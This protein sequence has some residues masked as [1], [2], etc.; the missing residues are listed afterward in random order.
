MLFSLFKERNCLFHFT[1]DIFTFEIKRECRPLFL[2]I[3]RKFPNRDPRHE[4]NNELHSAIDNSTR[5]T[6]RYDLN[7]TLNFIKT[8]LV[9]DMIKFDIY[10]VG[11]VILLISKTVLSL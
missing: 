1:I 3:P 4:V 10:K 5:I 7:L 6:F 2:K 9:R 11:N 8:D